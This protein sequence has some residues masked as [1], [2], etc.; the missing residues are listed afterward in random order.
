MPPP[1]RSRLAAL[2][3]WPVPICL[4]AVGALGLMD[5][6]RPQW[7]LVSIDMHALFGLCLCAFVILRFRRRMRLFPHPAAAD[8]RGTSRH[9]SRM[10]YLLLG[11]AVA[12]KELS[13]SSMENLR[14]YLL[15]ALAALMLIR[16]SALLHWGAAQRR[17]ARSA[18]RTRLAQAPRMPR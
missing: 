9:L 5:H 10:V 14:D 6:P 7:D 13:G 4:I 17:A 2:S 16:L 1:I 15:Y 12:F 3:E 11:L 8:I 18:D